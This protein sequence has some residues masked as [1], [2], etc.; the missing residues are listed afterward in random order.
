MGRFNS[1]TFTYKCRI[2]TGYLKMS[3]QWQNKVYYPKLYLS[4]KNNITHRPSIWLIYSKCEIVLHNFFV[5]S[6]GSNLSTSALEYIMG[7]LHV[8][9]LRAFKF[10]SN[11]L[12]GHV[13]RPETWQR[14]PGRN[15][16]QLT[17]SCSCIRYKR[18]LYKRT[19]LLIEVPSS[20]PCCGQTSDKLGAFHR[21]AQ[22]LQYSKQNFLLAIRLQWP[23]QQQQFYSS[24]IMFMTPHVP[25]SIPQSDRENTRRVTTMTVKRGTLSFD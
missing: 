12:F 10:L 2:E 15:R 7:D 16:N 1:L 8:E 25:A 14:A 21:V 19:P 4:R 17:A 18:T 11:F 13:E 6:T 5:S 22:G 9:M 20:P 23:G 24:W 3:L